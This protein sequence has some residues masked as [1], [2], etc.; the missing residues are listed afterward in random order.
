MKNIYMSNLIVL[1]SG[2]GTNLQAIIDACQTKI[3]NANI[4]LVVSNKANAGG[5]KRAQE[6]AIPTHCSVSLQNLPMKIQ[7]LFFQAC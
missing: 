5:L 7:C 6:H 1:V 4:I 3:L 2:E